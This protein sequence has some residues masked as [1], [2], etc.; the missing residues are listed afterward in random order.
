MRLILRYRLDGKE[1]WISVECS[2]EYCR[3]GGS[4]I[5]VLGMLE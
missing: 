3:F 1:I 5:L 2:G 4:W